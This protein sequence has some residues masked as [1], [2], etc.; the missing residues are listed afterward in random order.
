MKGIT[1]LKIGLVLILSIE[2]MAL[3][4]GFLINDLSDKESQEFIDKLNP[5]EQ[6]QLS[7]IYSKYPDTTSYDA[8]LSTVGIL[9]W[10]ELAMIGFLLYK[11]WKVEKI[12]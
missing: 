1:K 5:T 10:V 4:G 7:A 9:V 3:S 8:A 6:N 11:V 2:L 12:E